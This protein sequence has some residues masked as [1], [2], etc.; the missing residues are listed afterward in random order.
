[1]NAPAAKHYLRILAEQLVHHAAGNG[2][3][4]QRR[5][6]RERDDPAPVERFLAVRVFEQLRDLNWCGDQGKAEHADTDADVIERADFLEAGKRRRDRDG[7][8]FA[9]LRGLE[10]SAE[11]D[12]LLV[13]T[14]RRLFQQEGEHRKDDGRNRE[15][16]ERPSPTLVTASSVSD[17]TREKGS[18]Q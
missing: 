17:R 12:E 4:Y 14:A 18:Y 1:M 6:P 7:K 8:L 5:E 9:D 10:L 13:A 16:E 3:R 11:N 15:D 2:D